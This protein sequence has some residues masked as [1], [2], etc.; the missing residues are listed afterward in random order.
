M[1]LH[2]LEGN[3]QG[4]KATL[5]RGRFPDILTPDFQGSLEQRMAALA[6]LLGEDQGWTLIGSSF[7]G[8]MAALWA[9]RRPWQVRRLVLLAPALVWPDFAA[10][11]E[12]Q[13]FRPVTVPAL[14][15]HGRRDEIV[16]LAPVRHLAQR[17]FTTLEFHEV[18]DDHGLYQTV[19][20]LDWQ[21]ILDD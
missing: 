10:L 20:A 16:P 18:D 2:G 21:T 4:V 7:G 12:R 13:D 11:V 5:L 14:V 6:N 8:L 17:A 19:H 3:S 1:F 9:L 15:Y